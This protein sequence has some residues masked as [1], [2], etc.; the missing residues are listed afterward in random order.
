VLRRAGYDVKEVG[1]H[2][3]RGV[4]LEMRR[5][6]RTTIV[7]GVECKRLQSGDV[8]SA[9]VVTQVL[10][11]A[12]I[13]K[14][15]A[16]PYV[17]TTSDFHENAHKIAQAGEKRAYL[18][19]GRQLVR[20]ITYIRG[21]RYDNDDPSGLISPEFFCGRDTPHLSGVGRAKI[22]TLAN[23]KGGVGKTTTA[24]YIGAALAHQGKRVLLI[25]LDGQ[26]NLTAYCIPE[27]DTATSNEIP[28]FPSIA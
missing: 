26:A 3:L 20:Y 2:W 21:S 23:N 27:L 14:P 25:D 22:L 6:G 19:N 4:D 13:S 16:K 7:G 11:A 18:V 12:A 28:D 1:P 17:I 10:G 9:R 15:G 5:P 8:V 24:Y